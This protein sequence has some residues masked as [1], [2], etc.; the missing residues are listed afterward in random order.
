MRVLGLR[1]A[2]SCFRNAICHAS[3]MQLKVWLVCKHPSRLGMQ[4][5]DPVYKKLCTLT[6]RK[7]IVPSTV[8]VLVVSLPWCQ[9][10]KK[11]CDESKEER[12]WRLIR[13]QKQRQRAKMQPLPH[14]VH[15]EIDDHKKQRLAKQKEWLSREMTISSRS[16]RCS[17]PHSIPGTLSMY[18]LA[19]F[20]HFFFTIAD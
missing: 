11:N 8:V 13:K 15:G 16:V 18:T 17:K 14:E 12:A 1:G 7:F 6:V 9:N 2:V 20:S 10:G 5:K 3:E 19:S 4:L